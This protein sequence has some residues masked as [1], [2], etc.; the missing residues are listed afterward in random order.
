MTPPSALEA[1]QWA[2]QT[3]GAVCLGDVRRTRRAVQLGA[4]LLTRPAAHLP[5][6]T[7]GGKA[8]KGAYRLLHR[9]KVT[10]AALLTPHWRHT[11][12]EAR[13]HPLVLF[14]GDLTTLRYT[15]HPTTTGLGIVS[16]GKGRGYV[17]HSV[18]ALL[19][20]PRRVLGVAHQIPSVPSPVPQGETV[21]QRQARPRQSDV[22]QEAVEAIGTPPDGLRWVHVGDRG[23]DIYRF[24]AACRAHRCH[25]LIRAC[26][27]RRVQRLEQKDPDPSI[28]YLL[29]LVRKWTSKATRTI[30]LP[31][32]HG[33]PARDAT[34]QLTWNP[35]RLLPPQQEKGYEAMEHPGVGTGPA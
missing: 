4:A 22:W 33:K 10:H 3:F 26:Q 6:Q 19:P 25:F 29:P 32:S 35:V 23:S 12:E 2:E 20:A 14:T 30:R 15:H 16:K 21:R 17:V 5:S 24:L 31:A 1:Q 11:R 27:S 7:G 28:A 18:L 34:V 13:R 8:L 9:P